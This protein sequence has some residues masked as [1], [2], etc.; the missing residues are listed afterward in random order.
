MRGPLPMSH[1]RAAR[2]VRKAG[3]PREEARETQQTAGQVMG[4]TAGKTAKAG[5]PARFPD[6]EKAETAP[7]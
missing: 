5:G 6:P 4:N 7:P 2:H 1:M 3:T